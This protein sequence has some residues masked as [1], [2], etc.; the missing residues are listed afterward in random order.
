MDVYLKSRRTLVPEADIEI[1]LQQQLQLLYYSW[2]NELS[3][4][5]VN[6]RYGKECQMQGFQQV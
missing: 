5:E 3:Q 4:A 2:K 6:Q 1:Q